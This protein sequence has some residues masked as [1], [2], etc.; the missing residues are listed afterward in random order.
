VSHIGLFV[1]IRL[2]TIIVMNP[3]KFCQTN[4]RSVAE[5]ASWI[6]DQNGEILKHFFRTVPQKSQDG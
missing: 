3:D 5:I 2:F 6:I 1:N 4:N